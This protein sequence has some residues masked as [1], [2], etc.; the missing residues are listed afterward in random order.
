[1]MNGGVAA[2]GCCGVADSP[3]RGDRVALVH[4]YL[5][6]MRGAE[7]A[8]AAIAALW[9]DAPIYTLLYDATA[10]G[11]SF[12]E[13]RVRSSYLQ[14][15][16]IK[17]R[18]FRRML[19]LLPR[20][21]ESLPVQGAD[22]VISSSSAFAHGVRP[23]VGATHVCYC[24]TP[25]RYAWHERDQTIRAAP[26]AVRPIAR[27]VLDR[28]RSWDVEASKRV[29]HY[30][31]IS[32][33]SQERIAAAYGRDATIVYPPVQT[34]RFK[35][36]KPDEAGDFLLVVTELLPHK[37]VNVALEAAR[38]ARRPIKVV[39]AGPDARR[40]EAEYGQTAEFLG[41][42]SDRELSDLYARCLALVVPNVEEF[43]ITAVEAQA[44]GRPVVAVDAGGAQETVIDG[45]TGILVPPGNIDALTEALAYSDFDRFDPQALVRHAAT[46]SVDEFSTRF[47]AEVARVDRSEDAQPRVDPG[48][49]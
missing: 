20:A 49:S 17:Q 2:P 31:A 14:R 34:H 32:R 19:P 26:A 24:Y 39:G 43:G 1:M 40:L 48:A 16:G 47:A 36:A 21:A 44:A 29:T 15:T 5:L 18:G 30:I 7:R 35:A 6:V 41:R 27:R 22:L 4:D 23:A 9:P 45:S 46:F 10:T 8:F 13:G 25:F 37:Q 12:P 38:R 42:I 3:A 11:D 28:M 33:L